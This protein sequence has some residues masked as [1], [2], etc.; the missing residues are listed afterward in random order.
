MESPKKSRLTWL[1]LAFLVLGAGLLV[2]LVIRFDTDELRE[3]LRASGWMM[4]PAFVAYL[5]SLI[6]S[7]FA[8]RETIDPRHSDASFG[9]LF[10]AF[11]AGHALSASTPG[12]ALGEVFKGSILAKSIETRELFASLVLFGFVNSVVA[13]VVAFVA[14]LVGW[15]ALALPTGL[16]LLL[17]GGSAIMGVGLLLVYGVLRKGAAGGMVGLLMRIP[18]FDSAKLEAVRARACNVDRRILVF[19]RRRPEAFRACLI[20]AFLLRVAQVLEGYFFLHAVLPDASFGWTLAFSFVL[21]SATQI[22]LWAAAF[23]P[24][25][26][27]VSEGATAL[28]FSATGL[29]PVLGLS[30]EIL[31]RIRRVVGI[32]IGLLIGAVM[33]FRFRRR[34]PRPRRPLRE[35]HAR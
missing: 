21:Q 6:G 3:R 10:G 27:G 26:L 23:V 9:Q 25:Q 2:F 4:L 20:W 35:E 28:L 24:S 14:A 5:G 16:A 30:V 12:G 31:R 17:V 29:D 7:T 15:V 18:F 8:W 32:A 1:N 19:R 13:I 11:W 34:G 33:S 22:V